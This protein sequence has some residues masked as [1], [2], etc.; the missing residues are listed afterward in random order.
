M[1]RKRRRCYEV[2]PE[3]GEC[4]FLRFWVKRDKEKCYFWAT[5]RQWPFPMVFSASHLLATWGDRTILE[6]KVVAKYIKKAK[7]N[8]VPPKDGLFLDTSFAKSYP[9]LSEFLTLEE[10]GGKPRTTSTLSLSVVQGRWC[11][12]LNDRD[13]DSFVCLSGES[14]DGVLSVLEAA[15]VTGTAEWRRRAGKA[16]QRA[17]KGQKGRG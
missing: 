13:D 6:S 17:T 15:L 8:A 16:S 12:F 2:Y 14:L 4:S 10:D 1:T 9:A 5:E 7:A 11:L 3:E